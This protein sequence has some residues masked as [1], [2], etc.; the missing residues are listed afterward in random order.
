MADVKFETFEDNFLKEM[1]SYKKMAVKK[2]TTEELEETL[3]TLEESRKR[4]NK[5]LKNDPSLE[6]ETDYSWAVVD[7]FSDVLDAI[8]KVETE[9]RQRRTVQ[10]QERGVISI[11]RKDLLDTIDKANLYLKNKKQA[12]AHAC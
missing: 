4:I 6:K 2:K 11:S 5:S 3:S 1:S 9:L 10:P 7:T 12:Q 8:H